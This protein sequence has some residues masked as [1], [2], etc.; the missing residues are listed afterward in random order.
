MKT[1]KSYSPL[2]SFHLKENKKEIKTE[3]I[4]INNESKENI[5]QHNKEIHIDQEEIV[6]ERRYSKYF[7]FL[8][9][10]FNIIKFIYYI[11]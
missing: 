10:I 1:I 7:F 9:Y 6:T 5:N 3:M 11:R 8:L 2:P 4:N